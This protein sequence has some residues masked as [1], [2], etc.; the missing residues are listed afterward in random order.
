MSSDLFALFFS[1]KGSS[2][3]IKVHERRTLHDV[4]KEPNYIIPGIPVFYVVSRNSKFYKDFK[5]GRWVPPS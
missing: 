4:L 5:A 1:D 2:K 3:W